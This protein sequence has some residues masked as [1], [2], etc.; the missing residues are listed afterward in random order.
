MHAS[1]GRGIMSEIE[2]FYRL[3]DSLK[4]GETVLLEHDS[5]T[6]SVQ[7][8]YYIIKWSMERNYPV[9]V[10]DFL[11]TFYL[12]ATHMKLAGFNTSILNNVKVIKLGGKLKVGDIVTRLP[13]NEPE[14]YE[15]KYAEVTGSLFKQGKVINP[16]LGFE[17]LLMFTNSNQEILM[18]LNAV[19]EYIGN[20]KRIAFYIINEE[21]I[22]KSNPFI[23]FLLREM[24]TT[25]IKISKK[26]SRT[27]FSIL[28][29]V[30]NEIDGKEIIFS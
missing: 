29:S 24:A 18:E 7:G 6:S 14:V 27:V 21:V 28:R 10:D 3:L 13:V 9:V 23:E 4:W 8:L 5:L 20:E 11:D 17:R 30:N 2:E 25:V 15:K 1:S 19:L 22:E 26:E 12:Y 16:V